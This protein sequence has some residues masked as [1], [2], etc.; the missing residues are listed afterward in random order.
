MKTRIDAGTDVAMIGAWDTSRND[1]PF[2]KTSFKKMMRALHEDAQAGHLFLI[3][4]GADG[5]GPIDVYVDEPLPESALA[6]TRRAEGEFLI[7]VPTGQL[8]VGGAEDY[9]SSKPRI[10]GEN[11]IVLLPAGDYCLRCYIGTEEEWVPEGPLELSWKNWSALKNIVTG[12]NSK[13]PE[14]L[15]ICCCFSFRCSCSLSVGNSPWE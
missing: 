4:T 2:P 14:A 1:S 6:Q 11:S 15:V 9:R 3:R 10:T 8:V 12:A 7:R 13:I 5:G